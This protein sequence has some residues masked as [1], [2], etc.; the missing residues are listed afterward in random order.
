LYSSEPA[1]SQRPLKKRSFSSTS[2]RSLM[3]RP[4]SRRRAQCPSEGTRGHKPLNGPFSTGSHDHQGSK[5]MRR[6]VVRRSRRNSAPTVMHGARPLLV[7]EQWLAAAPATSA[8]H[9]GSTTRGVGVATIATKT[10]AGA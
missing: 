4:S 2:R 10:R 1:L 6:A 3:R 8:S 5:T 9:T 7:G